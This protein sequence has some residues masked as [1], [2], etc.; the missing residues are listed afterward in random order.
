[1]PRGVDAPARHSYFVLFCPQMQTGLSK[2]KTKANSVRP[3]IVL[4]C[5]QLQSTSV[6]P[7]LGTAICLPAQNSRQLAKTAC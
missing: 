1:M 6:I 5:L 2:S 4:N 7:H 3:K